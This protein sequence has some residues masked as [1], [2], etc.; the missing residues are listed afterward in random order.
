MIISFTG[1]SDI[2]DYYLAGIFFAVALYKSGLI[3]SECY[4]RICVDPGSREFTGI[5]VDSGRDIHSY[6]MLVFL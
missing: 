2:F 5:R 3:H 4:S 1:D 6:Y